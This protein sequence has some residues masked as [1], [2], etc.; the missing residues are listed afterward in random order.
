M[1]KP[2]LFLLVEL[3]ALHFIEKRKYPEAD[4]KFLSMELPERSVL[5]RYSLPGTL[6]RELPGYAVLRIWN[7]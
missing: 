2:P 5:L 7:W 1:R 6:E 4:K 3:L